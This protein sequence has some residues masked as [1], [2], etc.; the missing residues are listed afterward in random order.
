MMRLEADLR[1]LYREGRLLPFVGAGISQSLVWRVG[2]VDR[3]GPSWKDLVDKAAEMLGFVIPELARVRG[4]DLQILEYFRVK[5]GSFA[6]LT[7]WLLQNMNPSDDELRTSAIH[8][9]L[10]ALTR[11][12][13]IY[14]T[15]YDDFIERSFKLN[16]R[17]VRAIAVEADFCEP[18]AGCDV[19]KFHGDWNHPEQMVFSESDYEGRLKLQTSMDFKFKADLLGKAVL[20]LGY[21]FRDSNVS[22][23]FRTFNEQFEKLPASPNGRRAYIVIAEPSDFEVALFAKRNIEVV[24]VGSIAQTTDIVSLLSLIRS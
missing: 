4:T 1:A 7:N 18:T 12:A 10:A 13:T 20:F 2:S 23:L 8:R 17:G 15:N 16:G 6:K 22:Y 19:V 14:T 21:S 3:S 11:C 5:Q 24:A 9:E